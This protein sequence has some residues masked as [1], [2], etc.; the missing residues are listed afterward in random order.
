MHKIKDLLDLVSTRTANA[1]RRGIWRMNPEIDSA[2][3][4]PIKYITDLTE[5][6]LLHIRTIG[7]ESIKEIAT[8]LASFGLS[9]KGYVPNKVIANPNKAERALHVIKEKGLSFIEIAL[10]KACRTY[11]EYECEVANRVYPNSFENTRAKKSRKEFILL[12]EVLK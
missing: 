7:K 8:G 10:I 6:D 4:L 5:N 9:L 12:K 2:D 11:E 3:D 1:L